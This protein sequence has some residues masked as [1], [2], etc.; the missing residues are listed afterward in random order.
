MG[1]VMLAG[2]IGVG[3]WAIKNALEPEWSPGDGY[4][5]PD[6]VHVACLS[7]GIDWR[8]RDAITAALAPESAAAAGRLSAAL[9]ALRNAERAWLHVSL[10]RE[11]GVRIER[12]GKLLLEQ[13]DARS[14][15]KGD[16][17]AST[18]M[19]DGPTRG[20]PVRG[21]GVAVLH[22]LV[23]TR[24]ELDYLAQASAVG[25]HAVLEDLDELDAAQVV[26]V[27]VVWAPVS[28][29]RCLQS[30]DIARAVPDLQP[31]APGSVP[32]RTF[33]ARCRFPFSLSLAA[34]PH[35]GAPG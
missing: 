12:A 20:R 14:S 21:E 28:A 4:F 17:G 23:A 11:P 7:V 27:I 26:D 30:A 24:G 19:S 10:T 34:C 16:S 25:L 33:C 6:A 31:V 35:C 18:M 29:E 3:A 5:G 13:R 2:F 15:V 22:L 1:A 8:A 9:A 32:D